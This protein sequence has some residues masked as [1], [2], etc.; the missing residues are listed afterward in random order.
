MI[1]RDGSPII[2]L[3]EMVIVSIFIALYMTSDTWAD[4]VMRVMYQ[5]F[6][7]WAC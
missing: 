6:G 2:Y 7:G 3:P 4:G 5:I 1:N